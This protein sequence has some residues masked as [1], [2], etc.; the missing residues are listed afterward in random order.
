MLRNSARVDTR[1]GR[2]HG[3]LHSWVRLAG[4]RDGGMTSQR[5]MKGLRCGKWRR[6]QIGR[7][8]R[9][10]KSSLSHRIEGERRNRR[11]WIGEGCGLGSLTRSCPRR[12]VDRESGV[13]KRNSRRRGMSMRSEVGG[14]MN[15]GSHQI[16]ANRRL[17]RMTIRN[18]RWQWRR[19]SG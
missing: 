11:M 5:C 3:Q 19:V 6:H 17:E 2:S 7:K 14:Y 9:T 12:G 1:E 13:G 16:R 10:I 18:G 15:S 4:S 8:R